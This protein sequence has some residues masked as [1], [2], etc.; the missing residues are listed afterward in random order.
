MVFGG[1]YLVKTLAGCEEEGY[2]RCMDGVER[3]P[4]CLV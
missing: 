3:A 2:L 1:A 4:P